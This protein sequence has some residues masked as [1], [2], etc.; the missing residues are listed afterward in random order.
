MMLLLGMICYDVVIRNDLLGCCT[1]LCLSVRYKSMLINFICGAS[2]NRNTLIALVGTSDK[3][4]HVLGMIIHV[5]VLGVIIHIHVLG[6]I[7]YDG[8]AC[9]SVCLFVCLI[10]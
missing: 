10:P 9:L 4:V 5:H 8:A 1:I 7:N 2:Y 3:H 6:V